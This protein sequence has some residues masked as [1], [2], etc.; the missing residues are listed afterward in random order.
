MNS[1]VEYNRIKNFLSRYDLEDTEENF[2][3][4]K[5]VIQKKKST[6]FIKTFLNWLKLVE[7]LNQNQIQLLLK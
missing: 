1:Y 4:L 3:I 6:W 7:Q 2:N 5:K